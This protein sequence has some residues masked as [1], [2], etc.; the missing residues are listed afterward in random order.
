[1][2]KTG[3]KAS[4]VAAFAVISMLGLSS[5]CRGFFVNPTLTSITITPSSPSVQVGGTQALVAT[6]NY[7]DGTTKNLTG[8]ATWTSS[9]TSQ[10]FI[11]LSS[12]GVVTGIKNTTTGV[13]VTATYKGISGT[14]SV[15]VGTQ[16]LVITSVP[17]STISLS[18]HP[19]GSTITF[20]ATLNGVDVTSSTTF[21]APNATVIDLSSGNP[22]T[23]VAQGT[24]TV[25]GNDGSA[26]GTLSVT[27]GP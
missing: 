12:T 26:T 11:T 7:D 21:S 25:T 1:M 24:V 17:A 20:T 5:G 13:T 8:L 27:V 4:L 2:L 6:G 16:T 15:T 22:G 23:I 19:A 3:R 14:A 9:D 10:T 18:L